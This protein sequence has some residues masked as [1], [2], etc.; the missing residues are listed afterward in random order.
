MDLID[1]YQQ[2]EIKFFRTITGIREH[3]R[4]KEFDQWFKKYQQ[5]LKDLYY[6]ENLNLDFDEFSRVI[7]SERRRL[8]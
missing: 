1:S 5:E 6:L 3:Y 7:Y 8:L 4:Q 2:R